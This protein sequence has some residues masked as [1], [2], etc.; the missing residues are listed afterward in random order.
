M[1]NNNQSVSLGGGL[2]FSPDLRPSMC[3]VQ[4]IEGIVRAR[5]AS[6]IFHNAALEFSKSNS[7]RFCCLLN[8]EVIISFA[9]YFIRKATVSGE[10]LVGISLGIVTT[11]EAF[12]GKGYARRL[13]C[14]L[15]KY[16]LQHNWNFIYLQG[17]P[18]F[19]Y[20]LGYRAFAP[21][22]KFIVDLKHCSDNRGSIR[23]ATQADLNLLK[24]LYESYGKTC[25][26]F[27]NRADEDWIDLLGPLAK[28]FLFYRPSLVFDA[29][30]RAV[31][32]F[33]STPNEPECVRELVFWPNL[34]SAKSMLEVMS[35]LP[36]FANKSKLE[37]F[38]PLSSPLR[39]IAETSFS[40]DFIC[41]YRPYSS[42]M[43]KWLGNTLVNNKLFDRFI[44]QGDNL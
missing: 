23:D 10:K 28:S 21:K 32:Y 17:I 27:V 38:A 41:Y 39:N 14:E 12:S 4:E 26:S 44:F 16:G 1:Q 15:E 40:A 8:A 29:P 30:G 25:G 33:A 6:Q 5:H 31:G 24:A 3:Q 2:Y 22:S 34:Q 37:I 11:S 42:N 35:K 7:I 36:A 9:Y 13:L 19:Y 20:N 43:I 18:D